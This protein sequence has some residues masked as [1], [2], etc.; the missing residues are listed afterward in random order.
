MVAFTIKIVNLNE[1]LSKI[2]GITDEKL[3]KADDGIKKAGFFIESEVKASI[4]G[5]RA[6]LRSVDTGRFLNS[7]STTFPQQLT[8]SVGTNVE[9]APELEYGTTKIAPRAHF[10]NTA[11]RNKDQIKTI[12]LNEIKS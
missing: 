8:A 12:I 10:K 7:V 3:K 6:E 9:Y 5:Q 1:T 2:K 4:A 11:I